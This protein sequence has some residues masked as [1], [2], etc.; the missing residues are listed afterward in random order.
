MAAIATTSSDV[1]INGDVFEP[2]TIRTARLVLEPA[3]L[4]VARSVLAGDGPAAARGWPGPEA[5]Q[6]FRFA[7]DFGGDP[8]WLILLD[9]QVVGE[10]GTHGPPDLEGVV[11]IRYGIA[12]SA[13]GQGLGSEAC[14]ALTE[15]L[16]GRPGVARVAASTDTAANP[17]SRRVLERSGFLLDHL[18]GATAWYVRYEQTDVPD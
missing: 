12:V 16:L 17:A 13:R 11:E 18:D 5:L 9:G 7:V 15:W 4:D 8:G 10:C 2:A 1:R 6:A 14:A 3:G